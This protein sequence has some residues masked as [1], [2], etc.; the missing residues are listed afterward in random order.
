MASGWFDRPVPINE[1]RGS[2]RNVSSA[3]EAAGILLNDW[4]SEGGRRH[5]AARKACLEVLQGIKEGMHARRAFEA[6]AKE[7]G[8]ISAASRSTRDARTVR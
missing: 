7:A 8:I 5:R 1:R 4:P 2:I 3:Q 6:A